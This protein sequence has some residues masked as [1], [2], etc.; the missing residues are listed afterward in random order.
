MK[1]RRYLETRGVDWRALDANPTASKWDKLWRWHPRP[2]RTYWEWK[3]GVAG[4]ELIKRE[5]KAP[6]G[7][8]VLGLVSH[9]LK[10]VAV[11][12]IY[13]GAA[14]GKIEYGLDSKG[15]GVLVK[16]TLGSLCGDDRE[17]GSRG[18]VTCRLTGRVASGILC[19]CEGADATGPSVLQGVMDGPDGGAAVWPCLS[20]E[21]LRAFRLSKHEAEWVR[22][23]Q[24]CGDYDKSKA[25][26]KAAAA[27]GSN[28]LK[29]VQGEEWKSWGGGE[30]DVRICMPD[31][32]VSEELVGEMNACH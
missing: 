11:Q 2:H 30:V 3:D 12:R 4:G 31:A 29:Q 15:S 23:V 10:I 9:E 14:G 7:A 13:L 5:E 17:G 19:V 26:Q 21:G 8:L 25:G 6:H 32:R 22:A 18:G 16:A 27:C 28:L 20:T 24:I 1:A